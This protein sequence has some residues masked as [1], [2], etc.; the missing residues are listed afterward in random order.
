MKGLSEM[1]QA[2]NSDFGSDREVQHVAR[3]GVWVHI[4]H[5]PKD[6][7]LVELAQRS[8]SGYSKGSKWPERKGLVTIYITK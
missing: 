6:A 1:L 3:D 2:P 7:A 8:L 5:L 4:R